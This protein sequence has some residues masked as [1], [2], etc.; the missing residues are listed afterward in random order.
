MFFSIVQIH[1]GARLFLK[2][3]TEPIVCGSISS[4]SSQTTSVS[5]SNIFP[6]C[7][8]SNNSSCLKRSEIDQRWQNSSSNGRFPSDFSFLDSNSN[9]N[10][11]HLEN[12]ILLN[13]NNDSLTKR[14]DLRPEEQKKFYHLVRIS[15]E[16]DIFSRKTKRI[17]A[18]LF[19]GETEQPRRR[20]SLFSHE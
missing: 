8:S 10:R 12:Q 15:Q 20:R 18:L 3:K 5:P 14:K 17:F 9:K 13:S 19:Q 4:I 7:Y 2:L 1:D 6:N 16:L 11:N